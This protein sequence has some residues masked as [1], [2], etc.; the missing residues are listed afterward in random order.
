VLG[1]RSGAANPW[2]RYLE[3]KQRAPTSLTRDL[4]G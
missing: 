2:G 4:A 3:V 1:F